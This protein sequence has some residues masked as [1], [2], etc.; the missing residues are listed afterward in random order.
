MTVVL[1]DWDV[2]IGLDAALRGQAADPEEVRR[3]RPQ[4]IAVTAEA[5]EEAGRL[6]RPAVLARRLTV[7]AVARGMLDLDS[8]RFECG[9]W[10][11]GRMAEAVEVIAVVCTIGHALEDKVSAIFPSDPALALALDGTGSAAVDALSADACE[12][13]RGEGAGRGLPG[14]VQCW[15]GSTEWPTEAGQP[16]IFGLVDPDGRHAETVRLLPSRLMRPVKSVAFL[17]GLTAQAT[18]VDDQCASCSLAAV[19]RHRPRPREPDDR[20]LAGERAG[21]YWDEGDQREEGGV[22]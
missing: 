17:L 19:C 20:G 4:I 8:G 2:R 10:V 18:A 22:L 13:W 9:D 15:P 14:M 6:I 3:R 21:E 12:R 1:T 5:V 7:R 16:Q 11:A